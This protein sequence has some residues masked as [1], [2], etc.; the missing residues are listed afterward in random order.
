MIAWMRELGSGQHP[1]TD[2]NQGLL[3]DDTRTG[4]AVAGMWLI[5]TR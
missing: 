5:P 3:V 1:Y 2:V 4:K